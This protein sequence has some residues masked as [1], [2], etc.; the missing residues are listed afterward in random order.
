VRVTYFYAGI[1]LIEKG[2][3]ADYSGY[4]CSI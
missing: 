2:L 1:T 4:P 3:R